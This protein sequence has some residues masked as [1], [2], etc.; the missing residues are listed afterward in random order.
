MLARCISEQIDHMDDFADYRSLRDEDFSIKCFK[1]C[2]L[3]RNR[4]E[5]EIL[6]NP[7]FKFTLSIQ[8][9]IEL[10][11][12][13][14]REFR[15]QFL[16]SQYT[17]LQNVDGFSKGKVDHICKNLFDIF[18]VNFHINPRTVRC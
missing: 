11:N 2:R 13:N 1:L 14:C 18:C 15:E 7:D 12:R 6:V 16:V 8:S 5:R 10:I 4:I 9:Y 17:L 3:I